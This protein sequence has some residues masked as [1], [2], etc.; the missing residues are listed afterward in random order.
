MAGTVAGWRKGLEA[1]A[2]ELV[3]QYAP[4]ENYEQ[5]YDKLDL[6]ID[7]LGW[8]RDNMKDAFAKGAEWGD[9][10]SEK[11]SGLFSAEDLLGGS[12]TDPYTG[13]D[14]LA[15]GLLDE[16]NKGTWA[17]A[18]KTDISNENLEYLRDSAEQ[19][20]INQFTTAEIKLDMTN[21]N[22]IA[23]SMDI[24]GI[25]TQLSEGLREAMESA[26]EGVYA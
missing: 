3:A 12:E 25:V 21:N 19:E 24:D 18:D 13:T 16:I 2:G 8:E 5:I 1:K 23:S 17:T 20:A 15:L 7:D 26:A 9:G 22:N 14:D 10:V 6:G 4:E 11:V